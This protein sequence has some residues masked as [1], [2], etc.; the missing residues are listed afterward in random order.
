MGNVVAQDQ[1]NTAT[2]INFSWATYHI[3]LLR[4]ICARY[5]SVTVESL[6][7]AY[8]VNRM[9]DAKVHKAETIPLEYLITD[10]LRSKINRL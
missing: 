9:T 2:L 7:Y 4:M 10:L 5:S 8:I 1:D 3:T 6:N